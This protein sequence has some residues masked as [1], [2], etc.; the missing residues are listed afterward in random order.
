MS[1]IISICSIFGANA[2]F[3]ISAILG[4][5]YNGVENSNIYIIYTAII[6]ISSIFLF[7]KDAF[8][9]RRKINIILLFIPIIVVGIYLVTY[10]LVGVN[11][12]GTKIFIYYLLWSV[13]AFYIG[14]YFSWGE[15]HKYLFKSLDVIMI[16]VA[17]SSIISTILQAWKGIY[18]QGLAGTTNQSLSYISAFG[19]GLNLFL[20][21]GT[22]DTQRFRYTKNKLYILVCAALLPLQLLSVIIAG[23]RGAAVLVLVYVT[24]FVSF[25]IKRRKIRNR[26]LLFFTLIVS[27]TIFLSALDNE[28]VNRGFRRAFAYISDGRINW[29]GTSNRD[30]VYQEAIYLIKKRP[31]LGYGVFGYFNYYE[32]PHN[33]V[34]EILLNG[35]I[36][37]L[38]LFAL[39]LIRIRKKYSDMVK[40][41]PNTKLIGIIAIFPMV[42][43][44]FSGTYLVS[45]EGW[46]VIGFILSNTSRSPRYKIITED[47]Y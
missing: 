4:Y 37:Y 7:L 27:V 6:A 34:L 20:N 5:R 47:K 28:I 8:I 35:G 33:I 12:F 22:L 45:S 11:D 38:S 21:F 41:N 19:F 16:L 23:G 36:V 24:Y 13:P 18:S 10:L 1:K 2:F 15:H 46:F 39:M 9:N 44:M 14:M 43:L 42:M 31:L 26:V 17:F 29:G 40:Y 30:V 32:N 3:V 25:F